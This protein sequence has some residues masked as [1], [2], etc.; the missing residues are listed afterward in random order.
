MA[1]RKTMPKRPVKTRINSSRKTKSKKC[2]SSPKKK[3]R[4]RS[5]VARAAPTWRRLTW[6][7]RRRTTMEMRSSMRLIIREIR[8]Q[9]LSRTNSYQSPSQMLRRTRT[10]RWWRM[11]IRTSARPSSYPSTVAPSQATTVWPRSTWK[12]A[13]LTALLD[14]LTRHSC[15]KK[16]WCNW[17][18]FYSAC[19]HSK[20]CASSSTYCGS[21][22]RLEKLGMLW[23]LSAT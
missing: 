5:I 1:R 9:S 17:S 6:T 4:A 14:S 7:L 18:L 11:T 22:A 8:R 20:Y 15:L 16:Y 21:V 23:F 2:L 12:R 19:Q 3:R 13:T 10:T